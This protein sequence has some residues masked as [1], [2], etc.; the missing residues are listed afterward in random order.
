MEIIN[1]LDHLGHLVYYETMTTK[2]HQT[3]NSNMAKIARKN[4]KYGLYQIFCKIIKA[5]TNKNGHQQ[6]N[7][8]ILKLHT[9]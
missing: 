1:L 7:L 6:T 4:K 9:S 3:G 8:K 2:R 5:D